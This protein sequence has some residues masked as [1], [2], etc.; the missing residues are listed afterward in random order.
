[1]T[2]DTAK[3]KQTSASSALAVHV[4]VEKKEGK[5]RKKNH[6]QTNQ[7][8]E[9]TPKQQNLALMCNVNI[10]TC[11]YFEICLQSR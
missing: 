5:K 10:F 3:T 8:L 11:E 4:A 9:K 7:Q 1:M 6:K 2:F